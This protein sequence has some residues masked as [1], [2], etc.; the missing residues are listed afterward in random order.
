MSFVHT[1]GQFIVLMLTIVGMTGAMWRST[2]RRLER[3]EDK[4]ERG[5]GRLDAK[6]DALGAR[7]DDKIDALGAR[8]DDKI[9]ALSDRSES[10]F[11]ELSERLARLETKMDIVVDRLLP[12]VASSD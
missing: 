8:L 11:G 7:L 5:D 10:K 1:W 9:D 3:L 4:V 2:N 12:A 6:I